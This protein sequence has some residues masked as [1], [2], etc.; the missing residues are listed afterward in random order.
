MS[1]LMLLC[2]SNIQ[3]HSKRQTVRETWEWSGEQLPN[4]ALPWLED[5]ILAGIGS[6]GAGYNNH[7]WRELRYCINFCLAFKRLS[8]DKRAE[9]LIDG[10][11]FGEWLQ[12][13]PE[14]DAKDGVQN[15]G[16]ARMV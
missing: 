12:A 16:Q 3:A 14:N 13:L 9:L 15:P 4:T 5:S 11:Q 2:P 8:I 6:A 10:W 1:W 7:R